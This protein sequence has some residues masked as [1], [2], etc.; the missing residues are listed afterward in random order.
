MVPAPVAATGTWERWAPSQS[1]CPKGRAKAL[2]S[3]LPGRAKAKQ[4]WLKSTPASLLF[5]FISCFF[6]TSLL[7]FITSH[8]DFV[9]YRYAKTI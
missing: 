4:L 3:T 2:S 9:F 5:S 6:L 8:P 7:A 1:P